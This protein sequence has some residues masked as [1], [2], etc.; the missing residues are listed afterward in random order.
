MGFLGESTYKVDDKGRVPIP[1]EFR[2]ELQNGMVL[3][4]GIEKCIRIFPIPEW[5]KV[6]AKYSP[7]GDTARGRA[8][9]RFIF[10]GAYEEKMD[11]LGRIPIPPVLRQYAD[12]ADTV[13]VSGIDTFL[14]MWNAEKW[15][16]ENARNEEDIWQTAE[17]LESQR[18]L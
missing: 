18:P 1:P 12:I 13:V 7:V 9:K 11:R 14:E 16:A 4:R 10:S 2:D 17:I 5:E 6:K 8:F 3:A 15:Q